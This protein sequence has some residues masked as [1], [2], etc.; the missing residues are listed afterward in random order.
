M[1]TLMD[2]SLEYLIETKIISDNMDRSIIP[3]SGDKRNIWFPWKLL[4]FSLVWFFGCTSDFVATEDEREDGETSTSAFLDE[5]HPTSSEDEAEQDGT[6]TDDT[7]Q[8]GTDTDDTEQD[9]TDT[10]DTG[11]DGT[12]MDDCPDDDEKLL[13]G[14]CG[15]GIPDIDGDG[16]GTPDCNDNCPKD[17]DKIEPGNCDCG[18]AEGFCGLHGIY[19]EKD[20]LAE[21]VIQ[22]VDPT[23]NFDW[24]S[25]SPHPRLG[26]NNFSIRWTGLVK[27]IYSEQYRF[28]LA[29]E[30][31]VRLWVDNTL[32][33]DDWDTS[34]GVEN[35][36]TIDLKAG[37]S[38]SIKLEFFKNGTNG[39][40]RLMW[41]SASQ[42][43]EIIPASQLYPESVV[44]S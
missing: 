3:L 24:N 15:C 29:Y 17:S 13:P 21:P 1:N 37:E 38:Y 14:I 2:N 20:Y 25:S 43:K 9:G 11:Q 30:D 10:G 40:A 19:Y 26:N 4:A 22:R 5:D 7:G 28:Y 44:P 32:I 8:D 34:A 42:P 16:D 27:A 18:T 23:I 12:D 33:I 35:S 6:D 39:M 41:S 31:G 36:G